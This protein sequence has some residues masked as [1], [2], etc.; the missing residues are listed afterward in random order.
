MNATSTSQPAQPQFGHQDWQ[1]ILDAVSD[2]LIITDPH[3][4]ILFVN[5]AFAALSGVDA[6]SLVGKKCHDVFTCELCST[7]KCP[8]TALQSLDEQLV[9][10]HEPHCK[11]GKHA[12]W[13]VTITAYPDA[14]GAIGGYIERFTDASAFRQV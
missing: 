6:S 2:G 7:P 8:L 11:N 3:F 13:I 14:S 5:R 12:P 9:F 10:D 1:R 4:T